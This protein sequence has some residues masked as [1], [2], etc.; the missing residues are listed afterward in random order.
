MKHLFWLV[1]WIAAS[2]AARA[3]GPAAAA[4]MTAAANATAA[5][6]NPAAA[7]PDPPFTD[8]YLEE[9]LR[10]LHRWEMDETTA[11]QVHGSENIT[12]WTRDLTE[13]LDDQD[14][15]RYREI[16][17]PQLQL[18][19][20]VKKANYFIPEFG[21]RVQNKDYM[22]ERVERLSA[23]DAKPA[24]FVQRTLNTAAVV[25]YL[26]RT[27]SQLQFPDPALMNRLRLALRAAR[28]DITAKPED[29]EQTIYL[30]PLSP[31][32]NT[33]WVFWEDYGWLIKFTSDSDINNPL[34]WD[35][36]KLGVRI[37]DL[38]KD[39]VV[40][41]S[42]VDGSHGYITRDWAARAIFNCV[43]FGERLEVTASGQAEVPAAYHVVPHEAPPGK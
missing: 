13:K 33:L 11:L 39:V 42:E 29:G 4:N 26:K 43:V 15:S 6:A 10:N 30:A 40:T 38:H 12:I 31:V 37:Y 34:F 1:A 5:A 25:D 7:E 8:A 14:A 35:M 3:D 20:T 21:Q 36:E 2:S 18:D 28:A 41:L 9:I 17:F 32:K 16:Y 24:D 22:I 23:P 19:V 27:R